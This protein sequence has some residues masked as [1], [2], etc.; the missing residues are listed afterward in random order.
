MDDAGAVRGGEAVGDLHGEREDAADGQALA[1][2]D[3]FD[4]PARDELH[5][6]ER[7]TRVG[8]DV[9]DGDDV[10]MV[11]RRGR[12]RLL[13]EPSQPLVARDAIGRQD[14]EC[15]ESIEVSIATFVDDTHTAFTELLGDLI[16]EK[17]AANHGGSLHPTTVA[18]GTHRPTRGK[19]RVTPE[20]R[21]PR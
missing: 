15:D 21:L 4:R 2:D 5:R 1:W 3:L 17:A 14:F 16:V 13:D 10:R 11:Q 7:R 20:V 18:N 19:D 8:G 9:V 6:H 12:F